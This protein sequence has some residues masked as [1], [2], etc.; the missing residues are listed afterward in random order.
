M[1]A[2]LEVQPPVEQQGVDAGD[3]VP[4]ADGQGVEPVEPVV[5]EPQEADVDEEGR[6]VDEGVA[7]EG[8]GHALAQ[9]A[10]DEPVDAADDMEEGS[11]GAPR[12]VVETLVE[13]VGETFSRG[14]GGARGCRRPALRGAEPGCGASGI[15]RRHIILSERSGVS[16]TY[17]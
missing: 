14:R 13:P 2:G 9:C 16:P 8:H 11:R 12:G 10:G 17:E 7:D 1:S 6:A 3:H 5:E 15:L 4:Q